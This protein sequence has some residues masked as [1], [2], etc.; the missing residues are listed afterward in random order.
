MV[1]L[2]SCQKNDIEV[3]RNNDVSWKPDEIITNADIRTRIGYD[4]R[5]DYIFTENTLIDVPMFNIGDFQITGQK[6]I[7]LEVR[8]TKVLDRDVTVGLKYDTALFE[9]VKT[10]YAEYRLANEGF[11]S[12]DATQKVI[13]SGQTSVTFTFSVN[14]DATF[15]DKLLLPYS[16]VAINDDKIKSVETYDSV[17]LKIF[18]QEIG[19]EYP[20]RFE[21][22]AVVSPSDL[23]TS[24]NTLTIG[25][26]EA[27]NDEILVS[28][29]RDERGTSDLPAGA[30]GALPTNVDFKGV[31]S[32]DLSLTIDKTTL[33]AGR[34]YRLPLKVVLKQGAKVYEQ[35]VT[36]DVNVQAIQ[37]S[38]NVVLGTKK[39]GTK[40]EK[41]DI[42]ATFS[43]RGSY[44]NEINDDDY[45]NG[46]YMVA[47]K[48][49]N[50]T[51][52]FTNR[53]VRAFVISSVVRQ[54]LSSTSIY[55]LNSSG[56][57][58]LLGNI[59]FPTST[60][61]QEY[62][63]LFKNPVKTD[64]FIFKDLNSSARQ[65]AIREIDIYE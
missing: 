2:Y 26:S 48:P 32:Q 40:V 13:T 54:P 10:S 59:T 5:F 35:P 52:T 15:S 30:I 20:N 64:T 14:N 42:R 27:I 17:L 25:V 53:E 6:Q 28:L 21:L 55:A 60:E 39:V 34:N 36:I 7:Q 8:L 12:L 50:M 1:S 46:N 37:P 49:T 44:L 51:V 29:V 56:Q 9:K 18:P 23:F 45:S 65:I 62:I 58:V 31:T 33:T 11:I 61:A 16:V 63:I 22:N 47:Q 3:L 41:S 19:F 4:P 38:E 43:T 24:T 57:E